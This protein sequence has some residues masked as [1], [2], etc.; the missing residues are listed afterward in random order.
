MGRSSSSIKEKDDWD[1]DTRPLSRLVTLNSWLA[2]TGK[3]LA[4]GVCA[5]SMGETL[6]P[7]MGEYILVAVETL[8]EVQWVELI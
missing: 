8:D 7:R 2:G 5:R 1:G 3:S 6:P 4:V